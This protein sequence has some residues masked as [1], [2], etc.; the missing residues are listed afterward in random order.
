MLRTFLA[1]LRDMGARSITLAD[2]SGMEATRQVMERKGVF[3][4][5][6]TFGAAVVVLDE[7]PADAWEIANRNGFLWRRGFPVPKMPLDAECVIQT[8]NLKTHHY[9]GHFTLSLKNSVG[10]VGKYLDS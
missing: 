8:C 2:R 6:K 10:F 1:S 5:A 4:L 7:L 3:D 9:G